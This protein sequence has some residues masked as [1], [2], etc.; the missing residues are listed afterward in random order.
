M[1]LGKSGSLQEMQLTVRE[2]A[3]ALSVTEKTIYRWLREG[4]LPANRINDQYRFNRSELLEWATARNIPVAADLFPSGD[5]A[6]ELPQLSDALARG[7]IFHGL[8]AHDKTAAL[9]QVIE[10]MHFPVASDREAFLRVLLAREELASTGVGEGI[11]I[12][13]VRNP[14]VLHVQDPMIT[15]SF[16]KTPIDFGAVD[17]QPVHAL[18]TMVTPTVRVHLHLISR[19]AFALRDPG[20]SGVIKSHSSSDDIMAAL[21]RVEGAL[22]S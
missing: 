13:H 11:A 14:L 9:H 5:S 16:L 20:F 17:G 1:L 22:H 19:L 8:D 10:R 2:V 18:F 15:L 7:G 21:R 6:C 12:P 4:T 3:K